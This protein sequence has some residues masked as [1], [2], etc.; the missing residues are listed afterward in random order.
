MLYLKYIFILNNLSSSAAKRFYL[1][2][3]EI[4][5]HRSIPTDLYYDCNTYH[6]LPH[7]NG[8]IMRLS[9][10]NETLNDTGIHHKLSPKQ[11]QDLKE[12]KL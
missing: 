6:F 12:P 1:I 8:I 2:S 11:T 4:H 3:M 5:V 7:W 10:N 9:Y